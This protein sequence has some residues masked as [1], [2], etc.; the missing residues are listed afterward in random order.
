MNRLII[1]N[2]NY[3]SW[4]LRPWLVMKEFKIPFQE[5]RISLYQPDSKQQLLEHAPSGKVPAFYHDDFAVWDSLA[6]CETLNEL[7]P[8]EGLWPTDPATRAL[9]RSI[10]H[11]MHSGFVEIRNQLPMNCRTQITL[12]NI[13]PAL[14]ADIDRIKDI[15]SDCR[16]KNQEYGDFLLGEFSICDAMFAPVVL[17]FNSYGIEVTQT[18]RQYMNSILNLESVQEWITDGVNE[19]DVM[20]M[21]EAD[22]VLKATS[23]KATA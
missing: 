20:P 15:W 19:E 22:A 13:S 14:Q 7:Y 4:S 16:D 3:S 8:A 11:E 1:G 23:I 5:T 10:G 2:K 12:P 9:G 21:N 18:Q 6:I 17:R